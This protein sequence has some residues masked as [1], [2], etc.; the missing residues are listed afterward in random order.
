MSLLVSAQQDNN[1]IPIT[2][3]KGCHRT[4]QASTD[5]V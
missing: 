1:N 5:P 4:L 2:D 3:F